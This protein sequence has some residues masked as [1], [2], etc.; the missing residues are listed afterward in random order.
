MRL[1]NGSGMALVWLLV[2]GV[3]S[4]CGMMEGPA[5]EVRAAEAKSDAAGQSGATA[6]EVDALALIEPNSMVVLRLNAPKRLVEHPLV[7]DVV[8]LLE[9]SALVE[10][11]LS[12]LKTPQLEQL[13]QF[14]ELS[15]SKPW[16]QALE[17]IT[18]DNL[19]LALGRQVD[20]GPLTT[21]ILTTDGEGTARGIR[22]GLG[23]AAISG[24]PDV[25]AADYRGLSAFRLKDS[26]AAF[27]G[28]RMIVCSRRSLLEGVL[29]R[30]LDASNRSRWT[31]PAQ[32]KW[33]GEGPRKPVFEVLF[34][35]DEARKETA[36]AEALKLPSEN[37]LGMVV[38]AGY[39]DLLSRA[40]YVTAT[41]D[42]AETDLAFSVRMDAGREGMRPACVSFFTP[43]AAGGG[44]SGTSRPAPRRWDVPGALVSLAWHRDL[45]P[46]YEAEAGVLAATSIEK[47]KKD[48]AEQ[49]KGGFIGA[50]RVLETTAGDQRIVVTGPVDSGYK[51]QPAKRLPGLAYSISIRDDE[52]FRKDC[53]QVLV[54]LLKSPIAGGFVR[55]TEE[56]QA[57][58]KF[59]RLRFHEAVAAK[60]SGQFGLALQNYDPAIA[61]VDGQFVV[62]SNASLMR[63]LIDAV[64]ATSTTQSAS[65]VANAGEDRVDLVGVAEF[66]KTYQSDETLRDLVLKNGLTL[67][68]ARAEGERLLSVLKR[69]GRIDRATHLNEDR[70][71]MIHRVGGGSKLDRS[72]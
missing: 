52:G 41:L 9:Q 66:L 18:A 19:V 12:G 20:D 68:E 15:L 56:E 35:L 67:D 51:A 62:A 36:F 13:K 22:D 33:G 3:G 27:V 45:Y 38:A 70:F 71:E 7:R 50:M 24:T 1:G 64:R 17:A 16:D 53:Y 21:L 31:V 6:G 5:S 40:R 60:Q 25:V 63:S 11:L 32:L 4:G 10:P 55:A 29:D 37:L 49:A 8:T 61:I 39:V 28:R 34:A 72:E 46:L 65:D 43:G 14:V 57:G 44:D 30:H 26:H 58:A 48:S 42:L 69:V 2:A 59:L 47:V 23:A 54:N